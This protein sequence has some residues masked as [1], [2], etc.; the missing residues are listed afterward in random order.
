[1]AAGTTHPHTTGLC[2]SPTGLPPASFFPSLKCHTCYFFFPKHL[3]LLSS[4]H[5]V[6][7]GFNG[8][9]ALARFHQTPLACGN[10][11]WRCHC[12]ISL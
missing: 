3:S 8:Q 4:L 9:T 5:L 2:S 7:T 1:M 11:F 12:Y 6:N 10:A